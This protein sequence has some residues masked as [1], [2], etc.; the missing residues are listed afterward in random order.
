MLYVGNIYNNKFFSIDTK[1]ELDQ[2]ESNKKYFSETR[3]NTLQKEEVSVASKN[4][5]RLYGTY[6][7][8]G[9]PSDNTIIL[10]HDLG[11][12]RWTVLKYVDM[13]LDKGFN[14]L[15]YDGRAHGASGGD[16]TTYGYYEESDLDRWISWLYGRNKN[17]VIGVHGDSI[18]AATALLHAGTNETKKRVS[19]YIVD[20]PYSDL[21]EFFTYKML[22]E[23]SFKF[24]FEAKAVLFYSDIIN[25]LKNNFSFEDA[26]PKNIISKVNTPVFF[27]HGENDNIVP[28]NMT[29]EMYNLKPGK[30]DI[31]IA[32]NS[33]H[34]EA[35]LSNP[36]VYIE[37]VY[38]FI[39]SVLNIKK[40]N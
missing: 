10:L 19:F 9:K 39:D 15:I 25:K 23:G 37:K 38:S 13:Y 29:E 8:N 31:Y 35:Y 24:E 40:D 2:Y 1:K 7:K 28:K 36:E 11:G 33:K 16:N 18:G 3:F 30:K 20:S 32:P 22:S 5:Y 4:N 14:V 6:I 17:S 12:S 27:I 21:K 34:T 26:S